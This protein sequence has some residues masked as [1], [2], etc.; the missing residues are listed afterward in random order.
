V[1]SSA[2]MRWI[3]ER[4]TRWSDASLARLSERLSYLLT[5]GIP[6][7]ESLDLLLHHF[8]RYEREQLLRVRGCLEAGFTLSSALEQL[9]VPSLFLSLIAAGEQ[10][11]QYASSF[12]FAAR[13]YQRRAAWKHQLYQLVSYPLLL[14]LFSLACLLFLLHVILPQISS[15]YDVMNLSLP[16]FTRWLLGLFSFFP[17]YSLSFV[18]GVCLIG[19]GYIVFQRRQYVMSTFFKFPVFRY[20]LTLKYSHYFAVQTGLLLQAG[21]SILDICQLFRNRAPWTFLKETMCEIEMDLKQGS[22]LSVAL[23]RHPCF[24]P[25][26]IRYV[27]LGETGG[28]IDQCLLLY[29]EQT[30]AHIKQQIERTMRWMEPMILLGVG[31]IVL[32]VVLAFFLPVL[33]MMNEMNI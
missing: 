15:M 7:L 32:V 20:W 10:H 6:L 33:H 2:I 16:P 21:I 22:L 5:A 28:R 19:T 3:R 1:K 29:S 8:T 12:A 11:G 18:S 17:S 9:H 23:Q 27:E 25:E 30:E 13:Y 24:T 4:T 26:L 31:V 14:L